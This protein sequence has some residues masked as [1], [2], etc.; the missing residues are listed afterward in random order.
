MFPLCFHKNLES[1]LPLSSSLV[2]LSFHLYNRILAR[3]GFSVYA[4]IIYSQILDKVLPFDQTLLM[5]QS[6]KYVISY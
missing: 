4:V 1:S 5:L 3:Q 2:V 6:A